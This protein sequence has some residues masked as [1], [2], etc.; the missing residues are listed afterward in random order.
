MSICERARQLRSQ[1][2]QEDVNVIEVATTCV[3]SSRMKGSRS[4]TTARQWTGYRE[5]PRGR[6]VRVPAPRPD[7]GVAGHNAVPE[8]GTS[9]GEGIHTLGRAPASLSSMA[10]WRS[11]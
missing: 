7:D 5:F 6:R 10:I 9:A 1:A 2:R 3:G 4:F 11:S 8:S